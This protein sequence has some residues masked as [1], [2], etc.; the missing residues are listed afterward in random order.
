MWS[1]GSNIV[2]VWSN[3]SNMIVV[4]VTNNSSG[5]ICNVSHVVV[6]TIIY[7]L[8]IPIYSLWRELYC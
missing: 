3:D 6:L 1:N 5:L 8:E 4:A 7:K 2:V